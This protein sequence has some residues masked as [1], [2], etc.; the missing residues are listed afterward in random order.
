[1]A[2]IKYDVSESDPGSAKGGAQSVPKRGVKVVKIEYIKD[3]RPEKNDFEVKAT[4]AQGDNK[5]YPYWDYINFGESSVWKMDQFLMAIGVADAD[6]KRKGQFDPAKQKGKL[7]KVDTKVENDDDGEP[8]RSKIRAWLGMA[9][10]SDDEN[11]DDM[12]DDDNDSDTSD[13]ENTEDSDSDSDTEDGDDYDGWELSDLRAELKDRGLD[14]KGGKSV[15]ITRL[16]EDDGAS[17]ESGNG[18]EDDADRDYDNW[19]AADIKAEL[20][21]RGLNASGRLPTLIQ[22]LKD[23]DGQESAFD[24]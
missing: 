11:D 24:S 7:V 16:R 20:K 4:I 23:S 21:E 18:D 17:D 3:R 1:M 12:S 9:D 15:L 10:D 5:N 19:D 8:V 22:R 14:T 6:S 2:V 13:D